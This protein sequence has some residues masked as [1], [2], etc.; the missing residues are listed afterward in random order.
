VTGSKKSFILFIHQLKC[1]HL[2]STSLVPAQNVSSGAV[3]VYSI[4]VTHFVGYR[5]RTALLTC[6]CLL[7][8]QNGVLSVPF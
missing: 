1:G 6:G 4:T 5:L 2:Q 3:I 8:T 7:L